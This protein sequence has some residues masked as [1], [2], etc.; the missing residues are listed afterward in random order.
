MQKIIQ[1]RIQ[2]QIQFNDK[3]NTI[4]IDQ[5]Q[6]YP[7]LNLCF[8]GSVIS[9]WIVFSAIS[10]YTYEKWFFRR[11]QNKV[12]IIKT[13]KGAVNNKKSSNQ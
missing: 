9:L 7:I 8:I 10:M 13:V 6:Q 5:S 3:P 12:E 2:I 1:I 11:N 4:Y